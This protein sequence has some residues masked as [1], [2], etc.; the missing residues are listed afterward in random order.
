MSVKVIAHPTTGLVITP[1]TK[2]PEWGTFRVDSVHTSFEN[3]IVNVQKRSAF[4]R[5]KLSDLAGLNLRAAQ[6]LPGQIVKK[7]SY[8]P[9]FEGQSPKI[10][11]STKEV[12]LSNGRETFL[13]YE[14]SQDL[15]ATDKWVDSE[16]PVEVASEQSSEQVM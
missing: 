9:F 6:T 12:V 8:A 7:E 5:G 1:S 11:P 16:A 14:Y 2:N 3:G 13:E 15:S 4:I 10:N